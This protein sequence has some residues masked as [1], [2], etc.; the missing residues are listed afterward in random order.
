MD[1]YET[2]HTARC[3]Q[4]RC[5]R[6]DGDHDWRFGRHTGENGI[7]RSCVSEDH[8]SV[9]SHDR[10]HHRASH[11]SVP[12]VQTEPQTGRLNEACLPA[13]AGW[14]WRAIKSTKSNV[15]S[16][17]NPCLSRLDG[18][19]PLNALFTILPRKARE[20]LSVQRGL[21]DRQLRLF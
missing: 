15:S 20:A 19:S 21:V 4:Y 6:D 5:C 7:R 17:G 12:T 14:G 9:Q 10:C 18:Y 2:L 3:F 1:R 13:T 8:T 11:A 16:N